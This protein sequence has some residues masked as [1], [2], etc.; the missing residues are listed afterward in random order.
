MS[1]YKSIL[2]D[3]MEQFVAY[4]KSLGY[5]EFPMRTYLGHLDRY[6]LRRHGRWPDFTGAYFIQFK[7]EMN[8]APH[9]VNGILSMTRTF[10]KYLHR[11]GCVE[12]NP[13][14]DIPRKPLTPYIPYLFS[15]EDTEKLLSAANNRIRKSPQYFFRDYKLYMILMLLVHCGLRISEPTRLKTTDFEPQ[16]GTIYI[17]KTKFSKS[18]IIPVPWPIAA[19]LENYLSVRKQ[20]KALGSYL[21]P[22]EKYEKMGT[23]TIRML[24]DQALKDIGITQ[25]KAVF[26]HIRFGKPT[27]HSLR[28]SFAVNTL[29][30]IKERGKSPQDALP[31]LA[32]YMGHKNYISTAVYLKALDAKQRQGLFDITI[33]GLKVI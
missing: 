11:I 14:K 10:F 24:F 29:L 26:D 13:L 27:P 8:Y 31:V 15:E 28:H 19:Q 30:R 6:V 22:G 18:R 4:R 5:S 3:K 16:D 7:S 32:A 9:T 17:R 25:E 1:P 21:F 2:A 12:D 33:K 23:E 20:D